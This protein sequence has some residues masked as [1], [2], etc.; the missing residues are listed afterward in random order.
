MS[1]KWNKFN[2]NN[3]LKKNKTK[4]NK[5]K[6]NKIDASIRGNIDQMNKL[7]KTLFL[8]SSDKKNNLSSKEINRR[9]EI[10]QDS[11]KIL[12]KHTKNFDENILKNMQVY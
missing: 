4:Y 9:L 12:K 11:E 7:I 10:I 2:G 8:N 5:Y 6:K 3:N 1:K